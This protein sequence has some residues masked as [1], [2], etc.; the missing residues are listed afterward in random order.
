MTTDFRHALRS[1]L[2]RPMFTIIVIA[3][4]AIGIGAN[5]AIFSVVN[6]V[7]WRELPLQQPDRIFVL[8]ERDVF[9][10]EGE[11]AVAPANF[12]DL[13]E[14]L[15]SFS[16]VAALAPGG[17]DLMREGHPETVR[18]AE[19]TE[20]F[21]S[22]FGLAPIAG[23]AF[24]PEEH[25]AGRDRVVILGNSFW[26]ERYGSDEAA[27]GRSIEIDGEPHTVVGILPARI[28]LAR[29]AALWMPR[30]TSERDRTSRASRH[31]SVFARLAP[32]VDAATAAAELSTLGET[33]AR[34]LPET[35]RDTRFELTRL[36]EHLVGGVRRGLILLLAAVGLVLLLTC[37]NLATL[38][39]LRAIER[40]R[41][42]GVRSAIGATPVRLVRQA[43]VE[44]ALL[45]LAGGG[46]GL[47][48]ALGGVDLILALGPNTIPRAAEIVPDF[49]V[50]FFGLAITLITAAAVSALPAIRHGRPINPIGLATKGAATARSGRGRDLLVALQIALAFLL[51]TGAGLL[52]R[53]FSRVMNVDPGFDPAGVALLQM[54]VWDR[55]DSSAGRIAFFEQAAQELER[56]PFIESVGASSSVPF[57]EVKIDVDTAVEAPGFGADA[58]PGFVTAVTPGYFKAMRLPVVRGRGFDARDNDTSPSVVVLSSTMARQLFGDRDPI[59][60]TIRMAYGRPLDREVVGVTADLLHNDLLETGRAEVFMPHAQ[61]GT[62]SMTLVVRTTEQDPLTRTNDLHR[63][64]WSIN[65]LVPIYS[66]QAMDARMSASVE[67]RRF[68]LALISGF[69]AISLVLGL[70]GTYGVISFSTRRRIPELGIRAALGATRARLG[71][72]ILFHAL[73]VAAAGISVGVL[74]ALLLG[75]LLESMLYQIH[76]SDPLTLI[77]TAIALAALTAAAAFIPA[78][79]AMQVEPAESLRHE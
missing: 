43:A 12:L 75:R 67:Q 59:G 79:R 28:P 1:M 65:P 23:R 68:V 37:A 61:S 57:A 42:L 25:V 74:G 63:A 5:T 4:F 76:P 14:R 62:G 19:V 52:G 47:L 45:A 39:L 9:R 29:E 20:D 56:L 36:D 33:I 54:F 44:T 50:L 35:N 49:R 55:Y 41:E 13:R 7:L 10:G 48:I 73:T 60:R 78:R 40:E 8:A 71:G 31:L 51:L 66:T 64:I 34:E 22:T 46:L 58:Q 16:G 15:G 2:R 30:V 72:S 11:L 70:I 53:S 38:L 17:A 3:T 77:S 32:G 6:G 69:S 26:R 21:F 18:S 24:D 27:V